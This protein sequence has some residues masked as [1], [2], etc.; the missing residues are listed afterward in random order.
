VDDK[1]DRIERPVTRPIWSNERLG[2]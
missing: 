1:V 2:R